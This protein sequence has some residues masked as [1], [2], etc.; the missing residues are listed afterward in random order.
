VQAKKE[1]TA[2]EEVDREEMAVPTGEPIIHIVASTS[3]KTSHK[4]TPREQNDMKVVGI[5]NIP[6]KLSLNRLKNMIAHANFE[7]PYDLGE[8]YYVPREDS[9]TCTLYFK[10]ESPETA[11]LLLSNLNLDFWADVTMNLPSCPGMFHGVARLYTCHP[12]PDYLRVDADKLEPLCRRLVDVP[13]NALPIATQLALDAVIAPTPP[14]PGLSPLNK[15]AAL[16]FPSHPN[17]SLSLTHH[18]RPSPVPSQHTH[19][20]THTDARTHTHTHTHT[21]S[22]TTLCGPS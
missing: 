4:A 5:A 19:T 20:H 10:L 13:M 22:V 11:C 14:A 8:G 15:V 6:M 9:T 2:E 16:T 12:I 18:P 21:R 17:P 7:D 3:V 1:Q